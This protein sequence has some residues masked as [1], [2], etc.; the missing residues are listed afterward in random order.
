[1]LVGYM[2]VLTADQNLGLQ[3]AEPRVSPTGAL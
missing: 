3:R 1:M 2:R